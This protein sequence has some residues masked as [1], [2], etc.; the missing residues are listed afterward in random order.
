MLKVQ[1]EGPGSI[2]LEIG[3]FA[4][5]GIMCAVIL[6]CCAKR[7]L[8]EALCLHFPYCPRSF[9][10]IQQSVLMTVVFILTSKAS[11]GWEMA[12]SSSFRRVVQRKS[13]MSILAFIGGIPRCY[14]CAKTDHI[15][16]KC[17]KTILSAICFCFCSR[18]MTLTS[19]F[20]IHVCMHKIGTWE[21]P[22]LF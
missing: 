4:E 17:R 8:V 9:R 18:V 3:N 1:K 2:L 6:Q 14:L 12:Y 21:S 22:K 7:T 16:S 5:E 20:A 15:F 19:G 11:R 13:S 10:L